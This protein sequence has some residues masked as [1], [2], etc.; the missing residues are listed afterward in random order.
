M[1]RE[2]AQ[3]GSQ[4][5]DV[6]IVDVFSSDAIPVHLLTV[7]AFEL[8]WSHL[9]SD[10]VLAVH[11]S[12]RFLDLAP[13]VSGWAA[14]NGKSSLRIDSSSDA[15]LGTHPSNW[16]LVASDPVLGEVAVDR[17]SRV[18][19]AAVG[20]FDESPVWTDNYSSL[21]PLLR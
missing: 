7:E 14:R 8:Y 21:L 6:L 4:D 5:F 20:D 16:V 11:V 19:E 10:G 12:N 18:L 15:E 1:E 3:D 17:E 9:R 2:L 13:L